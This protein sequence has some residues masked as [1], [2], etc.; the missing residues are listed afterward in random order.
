MPRLREKPCLRLFRLGIRAA[1]SRWKR[2]E[3][4]PTIRNERIPSETTEADLPDLSDSFAVLQSDL[5]C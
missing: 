4:A 3:R 1:E 5:P 2:K